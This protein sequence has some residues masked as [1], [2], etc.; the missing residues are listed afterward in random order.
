MK[1]SEYYYGKSYSAK[2]LRTLSYTSALLRKNIWAKELLEELIEVNY[3]D[4]DNLRINKVSGAIEDNCKLYN[5]CYG[6]EIEE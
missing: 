3:M 1:K 5:E 2:T 6:K 4:R